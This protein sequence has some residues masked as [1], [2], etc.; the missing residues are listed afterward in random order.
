MNPKLQEHKDQKWI[1]ISK[2]GRISPLPNVYSMEAVTT[3]TPQFLDGLTYRKMLLTFQNREMYCI[4]DKESYDAIEKAGI[5][6]IRKNPKVFTERIAEIKIKAKELLEWLKTLHQENLSSVNDQE[7]INIYEKYR[8][9]YK[10]IYGR[11]FTVLVLE[12]ALTAHL[13]DLLKKKCDEKEAASAFTLLTSELGAMHTK[14]EE[15]DRLQIAMKIRK[16]DHLLEIFKKD[17]EII[18]QEISQHRNATDLINDHTEKY[19]WI[20]RDYEDPILKKKDFLS[21]IKEVIHDQNLTQKTKKTKK[22]K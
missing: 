14:N 11:Y 16:E 9:A 8:A 1:I 17:I 2:R 7:L 10:E 21:K 18:E 15:R 4:V 6:P 20:T 12:R 3:L 19:F 5:A 22:N 13:Q